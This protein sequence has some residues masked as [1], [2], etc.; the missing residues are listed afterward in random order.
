MYTKADFMNSIEKNIVRR[1]L[2]A[3]LSCAVTAGSIAIAAIMNTDASYPAN[4]VPNITA[5]NATDDTPLEAREMPEDAYTPI[6]LTFGGSCTAGSMLGSDSYGTFNHLLATEGED[7]FLRRLDGIFQTDDLTYVGCDSV[8]GDGE[9]E[10]SERGIS[11]WYRAPSSAAQIFAAGGVEAV[12]L[13][14]FHTWDYG[15]AGYADTKS[16]VEE[17]GLLWGD[18]GKAIYYEKAGIS[19][20][21]YGRYVDDEA[22]ADG[23]R[24]WLESAVGTHDYVAVYITTPKS[25]SYIP[26]DSTKEMLRSFAD[27]GAD[28][29]VGTDTAHIQPCEDWNGAKIVYSLGALLDGKTKYPEKY[30]LV[31]GVE[32][33]TLNGELND[34]NYTFTPCYTYDDELAWSPVR[35]SDSE[36]YA[37]VMDFLMG[38]RD[39]P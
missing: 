21:I 15:E 32:L 26:T 11:E 9:Y 6:Y 20:A 37:A 16:S 10:I 36:E 14:S 13:H 2:F 31:L 25:D 18:H 38:N 34:V 22:D 35:I 17:A 24:A 8:I 3:V 19:V 30:T 27:C 7:Y 28:L 4:I 1:V 33:C 39:K 23:V 29:V 5:Q 12:S